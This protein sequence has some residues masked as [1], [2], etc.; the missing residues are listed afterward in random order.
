MTIFT[1][2]NG[3]EYKV[4]REEAFGNMLHFVPKDGGAT[5]K[6]LVGMYTSERFI[7]EAWGR[8]LT[9]LEKQPDKRLKQN[10]APAKAE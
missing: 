2:P 6:P 5:P 7:K 3:V 4:E 8:Y 10:K 1:A 9:S